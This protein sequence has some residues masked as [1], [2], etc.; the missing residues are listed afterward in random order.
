MEVAAMVVALIVRMANTNIRILE[1]SAPIA[2]HPLSEVVHIAHLANI[3]TNRVSVSA[4]IVV[5]LHME[6]VPTVH[7][8]NMNI[9]HLPFKM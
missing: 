5:L 9:S 2:G 4:V 3:N 7:Q 6:V 1:T 8:A